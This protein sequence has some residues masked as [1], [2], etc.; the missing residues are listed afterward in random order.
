[1]QRA[2]EPHCI[3]GLS[4]M[5]INIMEYLVT[6][7]LINRTFLIFWNPEINDLVV[8]SLRNFKGASAAAL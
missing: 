1:M 6:H 2:F 5:Y 7:S 8:Q 3:E 4:L